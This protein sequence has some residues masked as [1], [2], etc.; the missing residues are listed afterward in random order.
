MGLFFELLS[1]ISKSNRSKDLYRP[2]YDQVMHRLLIPVIGL[3][4]MKIR[5]A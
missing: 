1:A 5:F 4:F 2:I 3:A